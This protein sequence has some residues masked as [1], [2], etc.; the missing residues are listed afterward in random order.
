MPV[1]V[2]TLAIMLVGTT[3]K[4]L[5]LFKASVISTWEAEVVARLRL[6]MLSTLNKVE[7]EEEAKLKRFKVGDVV[8]PW[9]NKV[10]EVTVVV[11]TP[12]V[13]EIREPKEEL[14]VPPPVICNTPAMLLIRFRS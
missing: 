11:L 8:V 5:T 9:T 12:I 3:F 10:A 2:E 7:P 6:P 1:V 4:D 14:E 13:P